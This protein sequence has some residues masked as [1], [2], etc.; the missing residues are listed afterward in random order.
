M[1]E[2]THLPHL[3]NVLDLLEQFNE[4]VSKSNAKSK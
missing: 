1:V 3:L 4:N 2:I